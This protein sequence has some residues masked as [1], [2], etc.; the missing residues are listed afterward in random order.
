LLSH[1]P[2]ALSLLFVTALAF[3][4]G[5]LW[6]AAARSTIPLALNG[7]VL[8]KRTLPEKHPGLDD[9]LMLDLSANR[10]IQVDREVFRVV[11]V[12]D[13]IQKERWNRDLLIN[14]QPAKLAWSAD[15]LGM[16]TVMPSVLLIFAV[17]IAIVAFRNSKE[18][19]SGEAIDA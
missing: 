6:F 12:G 7:L 5:N 1:K 11:A 19:T 10:T 9:V 4:A 8:E 14:N 18:Q 13:R 15:L 16:C 17:T 3:S 2:L